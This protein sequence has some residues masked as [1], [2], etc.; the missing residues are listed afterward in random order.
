MEKN[1]AIR[2]CE[3]SQGEKGVVAKFG[4]DV[5]GSGMGGEFREDVEDLGV[6]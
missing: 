3:F 4:E 2:V 6:G 1:V 5:A